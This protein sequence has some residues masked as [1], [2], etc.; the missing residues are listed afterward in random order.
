M[1]SSWIKRFAGVVAIVGS[2]L[3][4]AAV[5]G[6]CSSN[7]TTGDA[8]ACLPG[9][10]QCGDTCTVLARDPDNCGACNTKCMAGQV[11]SAGMCASSCSNGTT[12][13]GDACV[14]TAS[15]PANCGTCGTKCNMGEVCSNGKCGGQCAMGQTQCGMSCVN[16][17]TDRTNCGACGTMC[18]QGLSCESGKCVLTCQQNFTKCPNT[19]MVQPVDAGVA[20]GSVD[21]AS[22]AGM[23]ASM[24]ASMMEASVMDAGPIGEV[25][26]DL[27]ND[28]R[29]CGMC[30]NACP[31]NLRCSAGKCAACQ[32]C[33]KTCIDTKNDSNNCGSCN[34]VCGSGSC[35]N[36][37]CCQAKVST[38]YLQDDFSDKSKG[39]TLDATWEIG[40][41]KAST[42]CDSTPGQDPSADH[43]QAGDNGI[44]GVVIG[45][46]QGTVVNVNYR[47]LTSPKF[48]TS[49][50]NKVVLSFWR[51]L[52]TD[53]PNYNNQRV[54]VYNGMSWV[55]VYVNPGNFTVVNDTKWTHVQYDLTQYKNANMQVRFGYNIGQGNAYNSAGWNVDDVLVAD[56][57]CAP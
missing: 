40:P 3:G 41:A 49:N 27:Q 16:T 11:C 22:E 56:E 36:N 6:A 54:E 28:D 23:D 43:T 17:Q 47:Y 21:G 46:C 31:G 9:S 55:A 38:I 5:V 1:K 37:Y 26:V 51:H 29:H 14:A 35:K 13:C 42:T 34:N 15:D 32:I 50:A 39:W 4:A 19:S 25:C 52:H 18:P 33:G 12:K 57:D 53:Y 44:A 48:D 20:D 7:N 30:G 8:A 10:Q 45:G 24:D 2:A